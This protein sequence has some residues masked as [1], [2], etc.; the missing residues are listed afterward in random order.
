MQ[1]LNKRDLILDSIIKAYLEEN[2]PIGSMELGSRMP[3]EIPASTI[4]VYFKKL[5]EEGAL[6]QLHVSGGRVP[7]QAAMQQ[8]WEERLDT[9]A[10]LKL[11]SELKN[12][13]NEYSIYC[14]INRAQRLQLEEIIDIEERYLVLVLGKE[15]LV[16]NYS[17]PVARFLPNL[18]GATLK[19]LECIGSQVGL[20]ELRDKAS[21]LKNAN[22]LL[23]EGEMIVYEM[24]KELNNPRIIRLFLDPN[25]SDSLRDGVYFEDLVPSGY[26]AL[27]Q[28]TNY[29]GEEAELFCIGGL[30]V[31]YEQFFNLAK[32]D[33]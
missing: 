31:D 11:G 7:T 30:Y 6:T 2:L 13:A 14:M 33:S 20:Y 8:Y 23:K 12:L 26:M 18:I 17:D 10:T 16:L 28:K 4:R 5:S 15:F 25:F 19:E 9:K 1:R 24:A 22:L 32:E 29:K 3:G 27:K 21:K